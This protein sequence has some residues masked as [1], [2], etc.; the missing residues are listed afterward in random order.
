[1][2]DLLVAVICL[3]DKGEGELDL[4]R[5]TTRVYF[6]SVALLYS[7][8]ARIVSTLSKRKRIW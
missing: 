4:F 3:V 2:R 7:L 8:P 1:M 6:P 5:R